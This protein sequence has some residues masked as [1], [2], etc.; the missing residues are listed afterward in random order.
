MIRIWCF[1]IHSRHRRGP[2]SGARSPS[3]KAMKKLRIRKTKQLKR[4]KDHACHT[5]KRNY[6]YSNLD[7][8]HLDLLLLFLTCSMICSMLGL[9]LVNDM[10]RSLISSKI[11][12]EQATWR[13]NYSYAHRG[14]LILCL[15]LLL[16]FLLGCLMLALHLRYKMKEVKYM[17]QR[18]VSNKIQRNQL[19]SGDHIYTWRRGHAYAHHGNLLFLLNNT[20]KQ[21]IHHLLC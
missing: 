12:R 16:L 15:C 11:Q 6:T 2:Q 21:D 17:I 18:V 1:T 14:V 5:W 4:I 19:I 8:L 13:R 7:D 3:S 10:I 20:I 9:N